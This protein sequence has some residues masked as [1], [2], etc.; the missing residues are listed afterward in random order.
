MPGWRHLAELAVE[1]GLLAHGLV[2]GRHDGDHQVDQEDGRH[3]G[4]CEEEKDGR[5]GEHTRRGVVRVAESIVDAPD[6][7]ITEERT[8]VR[9]NA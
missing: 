7:E 6:V 4:A 3:V 2:G 5:S 1:D 8:W 9:V